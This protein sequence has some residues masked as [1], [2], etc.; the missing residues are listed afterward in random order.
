MLE[1]EGTY[2]KRTQKEKEGSSLAALIEERNRA[3]GVKAAAD[4]S[5]LLFLRV[6]FSRFCCRSDCLEVL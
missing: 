1:V 6:N 2:A 5:A 4:V 3:E